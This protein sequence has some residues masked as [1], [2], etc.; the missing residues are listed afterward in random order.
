M[1]KKNITFLLLLILCG[2]GL[3]PAEMR[4]VIKTRAGIPPFEVL[5]NILTADY[6]EQSAPAKVIESSPWITWLADADPRLQPL[7]ILTDSPGKIFA[8]RN[9]GNQLAVSP[10]LVD[11]GVRYLHTPLLLITAPSDSTAIAFFLNGY[12]DL[13]L[14]IRQDMDHL[15]LPLAEAQKKKVS[16][17][18]ALKLLDFVEANIDYQV[19]EALSR[20]GDRLETGRLVVVGAVL[21][22]NNAY[23]RGN[24]KLIIININGETADQKLRQARITKKLDSKLLRLVG[25]QRTNAQ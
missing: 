12:E 16:K 18:Q 11:Y 23:G 25:R 24:N 6:G 4:P 2:P 9:L 17:N 5:K 3:S 20:Y 7:Q 1:L 14:E 10:A 21:D 8:V 15:Y 13:P 19:K 22:L